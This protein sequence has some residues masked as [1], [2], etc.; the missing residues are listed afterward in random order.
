MKLRTIIEAWHKAKNEANRAWS[1]DVWEEW[2]RHDR[3]VRQR[4]TFSF[5]IDKR[6]ACMKEQIEYLQGRVD[7]C[8]SFESPRWNP[9][10]RRRIA[11]HLK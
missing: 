1:I 7:E 10:H 4:E 3:A 6:I 9:A 8:E 5:E 2:H 11:E